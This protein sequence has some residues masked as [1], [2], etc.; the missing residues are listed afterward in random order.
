MDK[1]IILISKRFRAGFCLL[2]LSK[3]VMNLWFCCKNFLFFD[4][5]L[6][7]VHYVERDTFLFSFTPN[8]CLLNDLK[9]FSKDSDLS[10]VDPT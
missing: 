7:D 3:L 1:G 4:E 9:H 2:E 10:K 5:N 6:V 8:K